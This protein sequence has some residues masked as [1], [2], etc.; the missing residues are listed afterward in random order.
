MTVDGKSENVIWHMCN[1]HISKCKLFKPDRAAL[2]HRPYTCVVLYMFNSFVLSLCMCLFQVIM[3][4]Q[5][6]KFGMQKVSQRQLVWGSNHRA[7]V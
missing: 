7:V 2:P 5:H 4:R 6:K 3:T 1:W